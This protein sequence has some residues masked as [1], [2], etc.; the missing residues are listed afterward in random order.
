[1]KW[2]PFRSKRQFEQEMGDELRLHLENQVA[3]NIEAGMSPD[4]A[5]RHAKAQLGGLEAVSENC[6]E[7]RRGFWLESLWSDVRYGLR[8]LRKSPG[9]TAVAILTLALGIGANTAIFSILESQLW[10]ALPFPDSERLMEVHTV[11]RNNPR[12][13]DVLSPAEFRAWQEQS[14][15]F[16]NLAAYSYP[17]FRNLTANGTSERVLVMPVGSKFFN[18]LEVP[19][20]RG[21]GFLPAEEN[22]GSDHVAI[23]AGVFWRDRF[24]ADIQVIGR[25]IT[26]DGESY[27]VIGIAPASLHFEYIDDPAIFVPLALS[28]SGPVM[29]NLYSIGR[30]APGVTAQRA[31]EEL[32]AILGREMKSEGRQPDD[33]AGVTNLRED[34]TQFAA[35]PLYFFA[36]AVA[37]VL[38]IACVN[39]AGLLLARGLARQREFAL[40]AA[41]G[42][43][44]S[45]V[46]GQLLVETMLLV[47]GG[48][49]LGLLVGIWLASSF[50]AYLP[51]NML[52]RHASVTLDARVFLFTVAISIVSTVLAGLLP[53]VFASR[54][55]LND[56]L[57]QSAPGKS[58]NRS[59]QFVRGSLVASEVALGLVLLFGAGLFLSSFVRLEQAPRGFDAPGALTFRISLRGDNYKNPDRIQ[60]YFD[61]LTEELR[62][63][64]GVYA[65]TM[66][67]GL[68][69]TGST[70]LWANVNVAGRPP[71]GPHGSYVTIHAIAPDYLQVLHMHLVAGRSFNPRDTETSPRVAILNRNASQTIFG[72][73][74]PV[75]K[76]LDFVS[77]VQR[78]V[79]AEAPVQI[80]GLVENAQE[81]NANELPQDEM[82]VP[83]SQDP[84]PSAFILASSSVPRGALAGAIRDAAYNL[85]KGQPVFDMETMDDRISDSLSGARFDL[86]LVAALAAVAALLVSVG[87]FGMV[88]YFVQQRTQEFG[89]R[90]ALGAMP[91]RILRL[92]ISQSLRIGFAG[93]AVG[94]AA[95]LI[96]GRLLGQTLYLV[97]HEHTG[98][99]YAVKIYDPLSMACACGLLL[100]VVFVAS[101][102]PARHAMRVDPIAALRH[103]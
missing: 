51:E 87:T 39:T 71:R 34:W 13:W 102:L 33:I 35:S 68:P 83:F 7:Q 40:R 50:A 88:A 73:E 67:S 66:G 42:A 70:G 17:G 2:K 28:A 58:A 84:V 77:D 5:R 32:S 29:R 11:L 3:A 9:F 101:Y 64:P 81:F 91:A 22:P 100:L 14:H 16:A 1:M 57:R 74:N 24:G 43:G 21:R 95:A 27:T 76:V 53:A 85:D 82:Y 61:R 92:A 97:P 38:L 56:S 79:P 31:R 10:R 72:A 37:L 6:R 52:A 60:R 75:G 44:R 8:I 59:Q 30:L 49:A 93:L 54:T 55:D 18:T 19:L 41:L 99:L 89:V 12:Q 45:R 63:I 20:A 62:S 4:E 23:L 86:Y 94:M 36:G 26:I 90:L 46:I 98:M 80:V 96:I 78:G 103:E 65:V 15:S 69:L 25:P 47:L 48:A